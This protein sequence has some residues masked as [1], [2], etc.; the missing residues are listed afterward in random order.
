MR[1]KQ[2][3]TRFTPE[4]WIDNTKRDPETGCCIWTGY[5]CKYGYGR[6]SRKDARGNQLVHRI[7]YE[8]ERGLIPGKG[9]TVCHTC[10][11]PT[12]VNPDHLFLGTQRDNMHDMFK[13]GRGRPF[14]LPQWSNVVLRPAEMPVLSSALAP[15]K[16]RKC[17]GD[18]G[19]IHLPRTSVMTPRWCQVLG[20]PGASDSSEIPPDKR[21]KWWTV[22]LPQKRS[23]VSEGRDSGA[24]VSEAAS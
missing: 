21:P 4:W 12:C 8:Q 13:K 7:A 11:N 22:E 15:E 1:P 9:M 5:V 20:Q 3:E 19:L 18:N 16:S 14:G 2:P 17:V 10:D 24:L 23:S 6:V